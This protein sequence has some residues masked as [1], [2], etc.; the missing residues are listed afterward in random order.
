M[1]VAPDQQ[2]VERLRRALGSVFDG[3]PNLDQITADDLAGDY[4]A[5]EYVPHG[6]CSLDILARLGKAFS[7]D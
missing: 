6:T 3:D 1:F 4:P 2:D 7:Y 5:I